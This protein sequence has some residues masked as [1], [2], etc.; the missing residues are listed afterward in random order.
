MGGKVALVGFGNLAH[1][2]AAELAGQLA[3]LGRGRLAAVRGHREV[4]PA[5]NRTLADRAASG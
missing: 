1:Y 4:A 3:R 2:C 5:L